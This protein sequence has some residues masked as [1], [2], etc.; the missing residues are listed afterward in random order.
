VPDGPAVGIPLL[1]LVP[2]LLGGSESATTEL[3]RTLAG[4]GTLPYRVFLPA[5]A[6]DGAQGLPS[7]IVPEYRFAT[8]IPGRLGAMA[9]AAARPGPL[10]RHLRG[11]GALHYPLTIRIP[12][13]EAPTAITL[14]DVQHLDLPRLFSRGE[15]AFRSLAYHRSA[16]SARIVVVPSAFVRHRAIE[17]L[18]L[19][20]G[21]VR[22]IHHGIDHARFSPGDEERE[23][24]LLYPAR[25]WQHKNHARLFSAFELLRRDRPELGL[26]LTGGGH[27]AEA[28]EG[29]T[30]LGSVSE[31]EL[32]SL[33]RRAAALVFPSLYE[34][35]GLP[36]LEA[37]ACGCPVACSNVAS[38]PEVCGEAARY[39]RPEDA[40]SIAKAVA[41]VLDDPVPWVERGLAHAAGFTWERSA[42]EHESVYRELL[43]TA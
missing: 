4:R 32:V 11:L 6:P 27:D 22:V 24:F 2:G 43:A 7:E 17:L 16:R 25:P 34:G 37:M 23:A 33:Y 41:G 14:H 9:L 19:D 20:P 3:L 40:R 36:P 8:T 42:E 39:F 38:L 30:V 12:P 35:F 1:T 29:V 13:S 21:K 28:P 31:D 18:E 10:E 26:V 5:G 15:R